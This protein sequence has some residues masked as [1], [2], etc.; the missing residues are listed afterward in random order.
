MGAPTSAPTADARFAHCFRLRTIEK[1][2]ACGVEVGKA[3][4][5]N[6]AT[7]LAP[8]SPPLISSGAPQAAVRHGSKSSGGGDP[9]A[10]CRA[11]RMA[12]QRRM[13]GVEVGITTRGGCDQPT[14]FNETR[15]FPRSDAPSYLRFVNPPSR[16]AAGSVTFILATH[17]GVRLRSLSDYLLTVCEGPSLTLG[18]AYAAMP[19]GSM[20]VACAIRDVGVYRVRASLI[21]RDGEGVAQRGYLHGGPRARLLAESSW[22]FTVVDDDD[23][24]GHDTSGAAAGRA[25]LLRLPTVACHTANE[26]GRWVRDALVCGDR[27]RGRT[28]DDDASRTFGAA[29]RALCSLPPS[30]GGW[31]WLPWRCYIPAWDGAALRGRFANKTILYVGDSTVRFVWGATINL[32][33]DDAKRRFAQYAYGCLVGPSVDNEVTPGEFKGDCGRYSLTRVR[34]PGN[35]TLAHIQPGTPERAEN[36]KPPN[37]AAFDRLVAD[38]GIDGALVQGTPLGAACGADSKQYD[39]FAQR[40]RNLRRKLPIIRSGSIAW[41]PWSLGAGHCVSLQ[42]SDGYEARLPP[43]TRSSN[44]AQR[45]GTLA[46]ASEGATSGLPL[47]HLTKP[48]AA[49]QLTSGVHVTPSTNAILAQIIATQLSMAMSEPPS[50]TR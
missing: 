34:L 21:F 26:A 12:H 33:E 11:L 45:T 37:L 32:L 44:S 24:S 1:R 36:C 31:R 4:K 10:R 49:V 18:G 39:A 29:R 30:A 41:S 5:E 19:N 9:F 38:G 50:A 17:S 16:V 14:R 28:A 35:V 22:T 3:L 13:C 25:G 6:R 48:L 40:L 47:L 23:A 8:P 2:R 27:N 20:S 15:A 7:S 42:L 46:A 43:P